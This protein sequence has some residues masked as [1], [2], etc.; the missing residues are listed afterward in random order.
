M[1]TSAPAWL[2]DPSRL[3]EPEQLLAGFPADR[4]VVH[5]ASAEAYAAAHV[6]GAVLVEPGELVA[7]TP[8]AP[9]RLP[10]LERLTALFGRIG[11]QPDREI[12]VYDDEGG[13]WAGR[14]IWT[15]DV[16]GHTRWAYLDGG[17]VAWAA[18][19]LP[20]EQGIPPP[21]APS[22][23]QI[24]IDTR[25]IA[26]VADVLATIGDQGSI[27]W[28]AR[29]EAE[30]LGLRSGSR[31]AGHVPGAVNL[32]WM[33][34]MDPARDLR[35][36]GNLPDQLAARGITPDRSVITHCQTHHRSGLTYL[37]ARLLGFPRIKAYHGS[38]GEWGNREDTPIETGR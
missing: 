17:I 31:R 8:P 22:A 5:V 20:L 25:P 11:Y 9:G 4:L 35:L 36:V 32:D 29:S 3:L 37:A 1:T 23:P 26:E 12:V 28:D 30:Y 13:G 15:L 16:I 38:W 2:A 34:L 27:V 33:H 21:P 10:T 7:G 14:F 24:T 18:L 19:G 6:P